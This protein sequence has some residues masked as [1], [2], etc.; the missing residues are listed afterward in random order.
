MNNGQQ[1]AVKIYREELKKE[2]YSAYR[3]YEK[4]FSYVKRFFSDTN[5]YLLSDKVMYINDTNLALI[6]RM[7]LYNKF[8][9]MYQQDIT[10]SSFYFFTTDMCLELENLMNGFLRGYD[11]VVDDQRYGLYGLIHDLGFTSWVEKFKNTLSTNTVLVPAPNV[12]VSEEIWSN[13]SPFGFMF[14]ELSDPNYFY[15]HSAFYDFFE[16][17]LGKETPDHDKEYYD[18]KVVEWMRSDTG[19]FADKLQGILD[20]IF[21]D[22]SNYNSYTILKDNLTNEIALMVLS[23]INFAYVKYFILKENVVS[24]LIKLDSPIVTESNMNRQNIYDTNNNIDSFL[25]TMSDMMNVCRQDLID[26]TNEIITTFNETV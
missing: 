4:I 19:Y 15:D 10:S 14:R 23:Y 9:N 20:E 26:Y 17:S 2:E 3:Y 22:S 13:S 6:T 24:K 7:S 5:S 8:Y 11:I 16:Y 18:A 21:V 1:I 12:N 25:T